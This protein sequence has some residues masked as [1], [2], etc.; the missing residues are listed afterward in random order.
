MMGV[1]TDMEDDGDM[2]SFA[3]IPSQEPANDSVDVAVDD[4]AASLA[5]TAVTATAESSA[6]G[7]A[8]AAV[9]ASAEAAAAADATAPAPATDA[10]Q[11]EDEVPL[12]EKYKAGSPVAASAAAAGAASTA[13][14]AV[15]QLDPVQGFQLVQATGLTDTSTPAPKGS[16]LPTFATPSPASLANVPQPPR[17]DLGF[18]PSAPPS[19]SPPPAELSEAYNPLSDNS[20]SKQFNQRVDYM[21]AEF[22][23]RQVA[24]LAAGAPESLDRNYRVFQQRMKERL[25]SQWAHITSQPE[26]DEAFKQVQDLHDFFLRLEKMVARQTDAM[27]RLNDLD[28]EMSLF[29]QQQ[30][31]QESS[32]AIRKPMSELSQVYRTV[33]EERM[34]L[35]QSYEQYSQFLTVFREKAIVDA[36]DTMKKQQV[37]RLELDGYG[38]KLGQLEEKKLKTFAKSPGT[39]GMSDSS[40]E[41]ELET[42]RQRFQDAKNRYQSM[43]T[44]MIDKAGLLQMKREVDLS[45]H[46]RK[47]LVAHQ[48]FNRGFQ[49]SGLPIADE[50]PVSKYIGFGSDSNPQNAPKN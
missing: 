12:G 3:N 31:F 24:R 17:T 13:S 41:R 38:S 32:E 33:S 29:Y 26:V 19:I 14:S 27:Q 11:D 42:T 37:A 7:H 1:H 9:T 5:K 47:V 40:N 34:P 10:A 23:T 25:G 16:S 30:G 43:S 18:R 46:L 15:G 21:I 6:D 2:G 39:F 4:A 44:Q 48:W 35:I 36:L 28:V 50:E 22:F 20:K 49:P 45:A 8:P